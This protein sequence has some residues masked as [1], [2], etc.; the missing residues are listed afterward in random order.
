[1]PALILGRGGPTAIDPTVTV[2][3]RGALTRASRPPRATLRPLQATSGVTSR[4]ARLDAQ[5]RRVRWPGR[6]RRRRGFRKSPPRG[7]RAPIDAPFSC[8]PLSRCVLHTTFLCSSTFRV[9]PSLYS[10]L[11]SCSVTFSDQSPKTELESVVRIVRRSSV[12]TSPRRW[13]SIPSSTKRN[14]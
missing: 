13:C 10:C 12:T 7:G 6:V 1:M 2:R 8:Q 4:G 9:P 3:E 14:S 5:A 11:E